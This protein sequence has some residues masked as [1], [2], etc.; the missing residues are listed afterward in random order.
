MINKKEE[1]NLGI[2]KENVKINGK[3]RKCYLSNENV[4]IL[5]NDQNFFKI[6]VNLNFH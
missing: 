5:R 4:T 6:E 1:N 2:L 3:I